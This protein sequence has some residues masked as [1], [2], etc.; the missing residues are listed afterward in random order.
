MEARFNTN[1]VGCLYKEVLH[2]AAER[3]FSYSFVL[4][5]DYPYQPEVHELI[6][7]C[8]TP[9]SRLSRVS[10]WPSTKLHRGGATLFKD[11]LH[12][13]VLPTL[14]SVGSLFS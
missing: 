11:D 2:E 10:E 5:D 4:R 12:A 14:I 9:S 6:Q 3:G 1:L 7:A 13:I 8:S